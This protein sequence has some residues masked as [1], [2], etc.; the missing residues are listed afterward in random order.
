MRLK[1]FI[2]CLLVLMSCKK[3]VDIPI[4]ESDYQKQQKSD[5]EVINK[6]WQFN[7][8][9]LSDDAN[10]TMSEWNEWQE[11]IVLFQQKPK[12]TTSAFQDKI[13]LISEKAPD[14]LM[15][16]PEKINEPQ[17][18]SR[19]K[20]IITE[21]NNAQ[22]Y[23]TLNQVLVAP[24]SKSIQK[25]NEAITDFEQKV[26]EIHFKAKIPLEKGELE[27]LQRIKDTTR[28]AQTPDKNT[29]DPEP[30]PTI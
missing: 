13:N 1:G 7:Q 28:A 6:A 23:L 16:I 4:D 25:L 26:N 18:I 27:L 20:L 5:F 8:S 2:I 29:N 15:N 17:A 24:A 21:V 14:L 19:L 30:R 10:Q 3:K 22:M 12:S 9:V 11:F